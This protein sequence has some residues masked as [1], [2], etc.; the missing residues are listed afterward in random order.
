MS[1]N[2]NQYREEDDTAVFN[3]QIRRALIACAIVEFIVLMFGVYYKV[4]R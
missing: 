4:R 3:R 2:T 1:N